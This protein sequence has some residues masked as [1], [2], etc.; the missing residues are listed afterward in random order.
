M[1]RRGAGPL[2]NHEKILIAADEP[3]VTLSPARGWFLP[4]AGT[5]HD[6][7]ER[8]W[9]HLY[10]GITRNQPCATREGLVDLVLAWLS[11]R[12]HVEIGGPVFPKATAAGHRVPGGGDFFSGCAARIGRAQWKSAGDL[13]GGSVRE[14]EA[15]V[16]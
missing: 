9:W 5:R 4:E 16:A 3:V 14:E 1:R 8:V 15:V 13:C 6:S 12:S 10:E 2:I 7:P 11:D